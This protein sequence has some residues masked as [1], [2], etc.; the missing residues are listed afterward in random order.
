[1][2]SKWSLKMLRNTLEIP[3]D[4][5]KE[6][7]AETKIIHNN[8]GLFLDLYFEIAYILMLLLSLAFLIWL[9]SDKLNFFK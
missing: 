5:L 1:M 2:K 4:T 8:R 7:S 6:V 3:I 9:F